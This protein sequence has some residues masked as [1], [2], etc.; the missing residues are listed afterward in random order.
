[1]EPTEGKFDFALVDGLI[2]E[3]RRHKLR[4]VLLWFASW[5]NSMSCYAPAWVKTNK[6]RF[7]RSHDK[8]GS[9]MEILSPFNTKNHEPGAPHSRARMRHGRVV[10]ARCQ[11]T[12]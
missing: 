11:T 4:L 1:M 12:I 10:A 7:P 6:Q 8:A 3:A 2:Q 5:K 9:G